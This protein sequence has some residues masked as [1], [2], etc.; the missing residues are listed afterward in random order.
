[1]PTIQVVRD[2]LRRVCTLRSKVE[3]CTDAVNLSLRARH[4][5]GSIRLDPL[6]LALLQEKFPAAVWRHGHAPQS[7]SGFSCNSISE[8]REAT[9]ARG[10]FYSKFAAVFSPHR[11]LQ[12][13]HHRTGKGS[14]IIDFFSAVPHGA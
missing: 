10:D 8:E 3:D 5:D 7:I 12:G 1:M 6:S 2:L 13:F 14:I 11:S 4:K 9:L